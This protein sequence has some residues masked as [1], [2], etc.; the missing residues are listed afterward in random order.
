MR[1]KVKG[2]MML[3]NK[4]IKE[5]IKLYLE[6]ESNWRYCEGII[7]AYLAEDFARD[8]EKAVIKKALCKTALERTKDE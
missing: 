6:R 3:T 8:V 4:E 7:P 2:A 5:I 1:L